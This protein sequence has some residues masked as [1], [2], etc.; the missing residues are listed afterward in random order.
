M[1][2][3]ELRAA[4]LDHVRT[5]AEESLDWNK[6]GSIVAQYRS[7]IEPEVGADTRKLTSLAAFKSGVS[8]TVETKKAEPARARPSSNLR[9]F[10]DQR[11]K[12]LLNYSETKKATP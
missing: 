11:R 9:A 12:Y 6:L 8:D 3:P 2:V 4:Y 7:L 5:I 10:V 1:A